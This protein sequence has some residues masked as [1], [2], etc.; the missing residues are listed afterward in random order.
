MSPSSAIDYVT[1]AK[2]RFYTTTALTSAY[3]AT[4]NWLF[5]WRLYLTNGGIGVVD[6]ICYLVGTLAE[7][8][9][10]AIADR[11]G[12]RRIMLLGV[13]LLGIGYTVM[14]LAING[15][16]IL[17]G[18]M[19]YS[20]G[21]SFYSGADDALMYD[22]L[23]TN[24]EAG[25]WETIARRKQL[26]MRVVSVLAT[27]IGGYMYVVNMRMPS[28]VRGGFFLL[29]II[30]ILS[31]AFM[32]SAQPKTTRDSTV[33]YFQ[34]LWTGVRDLLNRKMLPVVLLVMGVQGVT[35]SIFIGG[36]L[37]PLMLERTGLPVPDHAT[38]IALA[39][40]ITVAILLR[41]RPKNKKVSSVFR[42]A[43]LYTG[44]IILGFVLNLPAG[45]LA[46]GVVGVFLIHVGDYLLVPA[47]SA[48]INA[49][50]SSTHRATALSTAN[51][52]E[53]LPYIIAAPLIGL[54]ADQ[55]QL[56]LVIQIVLVVICS[57]TLLAILT[58]NRLKNNLPA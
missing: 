13:I 32:D 28:L 51:L 52:I 39:S 53:H 9:T 19:I 25:Q 11:I 17:I 12:R 55:G 16:M 14:G 54:A 8:P 38:L 34:H 29:A 57:A 30:P 23:K 24:N 50:V 43:I 37:R 47:T 10:G 15:N 42:Q 46:G 21:S 20:I 48:L 49:S 35:V 44:I 22:Y 1:K 5:F 26:V 3:F 45:W 18:Y 2:R 31:M 6:A 40:L 7:V 4:G 27:F 41:P 58:H 56:T 36:L 33:T